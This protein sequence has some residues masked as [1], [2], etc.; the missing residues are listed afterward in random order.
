MAL[1]ITKAEHR[2]YFKFLYQKYGLTSF[3]YNNV[4]DCIP[5]KVFT[6]FCNDKFLIKDGLSTII[7]LI[8]RNKISGD[9]NYNKVAVTNWKL[10]MCSVRKYVE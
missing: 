2:E 8:P 4:K 9:N 10:N 7:R 6:K 5:K 3:Q 1:M